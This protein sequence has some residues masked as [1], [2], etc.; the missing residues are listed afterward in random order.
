MCVDSSERIDV[1]V[2]QAHSSVVC[3]EVLLR[4]S[5]CCGQFC[6][7]CWNNA[8]L[9]PSPLC[10]W[11]R[12]CIICCQRKRCELHYCTNLIYFMTKGKPG[13]HFACQPLSV[14]ACLRSHAPSPLSTPPLT[15]PTITLSPPKAF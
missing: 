14:L 5:R 7:S 15:A 11:P 8:S 3:G 13:A 12:F 1:L 6:G 2:S 4:Q 10:C 9:I